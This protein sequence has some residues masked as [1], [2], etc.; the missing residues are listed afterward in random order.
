MCVSQNTQIRRICI[1][2]VLFLF[3][4]PQV[5]KLPQLFSISCAVSASTQNPR[6]EVRGFA[7]QL[8]AGYGNRTRLFSLG[9]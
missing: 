7:M 3:Y 8:G 2:G 5:L 4:T 9:S 1:F 6:T